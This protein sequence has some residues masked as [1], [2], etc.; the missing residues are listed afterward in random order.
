MF[1][2]LTGWGHQEARDTALVTKTIQTQQHTLSL[3]L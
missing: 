2:V 3:S 1:G